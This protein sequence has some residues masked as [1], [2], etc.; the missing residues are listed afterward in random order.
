MRP[1]IEQLV[2]ELETGAKPDQNEALSQLG[3]VLEMGSNSGSYDL[4]ASNRE[5]LPAH[6]HSVSVQLTIADQTDIVRRI[7]LLI[8]KWSGPDRKSLFWLL[9]KATPKASF[10]I[11]IRSIHDVA[12]TIDPETANQAVYAL[13]SILCRDPDNRVISESL[14]LVREYEIS[15][16]L[17]R[18]KP[19]LIVSR[20]SCFEEVI[21][22]YTTIAG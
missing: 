22:R 20:N 13:Y 11:L 14:E 17:R 5:L 4:I 21:S 7:R 15:H 10:E 2:N 19:L 6:L 3:L 12:P 8:Q 9:S 1:E 16:L 18:W